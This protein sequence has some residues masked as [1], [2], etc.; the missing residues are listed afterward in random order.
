VIRTPRA[1]YAAVAVVLLLGLAIY[2]RLGQEL[3]PA[4]KERD[5]LMH[6]VSP[7]G[8]SMPEERRIVTRAS[9]ELRAVPGVN[10]FGSHIGQAFLADEIVGPNFGENWV[11][12]DPKADYDKTLASIHHIV[13][14]HPG[15]YRDVQ[16][17]LRERIGEVL[18]G[19][20]DAIVIRIFG[21]DL[22]TL[23]QT[24]KKVQESLSGVS[25][26]T[27]LH[28]ELQQD[29]PQID[30]RVRL[31]IAKR[32]GVK[33]GDVRRAAGTLIASEEVGDLFHGGK[34]YDVHVWSLPGTR[35]DLSAIRNLPIDTPEHGQVAL[36]TLADVRVRPTPNVIKRENASRRID[37]AANLSDRHLGAVSRDVETALRQ[38]SLPVGYHAELLGEAAERKATDR[39]LLLLAVGAV[40]AILLL[41]QAAFRSWRLAWLLLLTL[42]MALVGG[43]LA[44][45]AGVGVISLGALIGFFTVLGIAARNGIMMISHFQ[46]LERV[47]GETFG[48]ALVLRGARER[49]SPILM[50]AC[51]TGLALLPLV[52]FGDKP[53]QEI[54]HPMAVVIL[55]G[56]VT[57]TLL[58]LFVVPALYLRFAKPIETPVR[59][60]GRPV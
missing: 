47:E 30:V 37:V 4:F 11:S 6:W 20:G 56:L 51:A 19:A 58:N 32:Y 29:V 27:E 46:H 57:S 21:D 23:R 10:G 3:F 50:T 40:L 1:A 52:V 48:P 5:F 17:Y 15:L 31:P 14:Q 28:T 35:R 2:P 49:L 59:P 53:G 54:E 34:A 25:G 39:R 44:A 33:P 16:T 22:R 7:P 9:N 42:P 55:G 26:L 60:A 13:D 8:T 43:V 45:Y 36:S 24:A 38:V 18:S 12:V 41:L